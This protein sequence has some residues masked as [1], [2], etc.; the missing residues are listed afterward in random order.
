M[1][2]GYGETGAQ[3]HSFTNKGHSAGTLEEG[4]PTSMLSVPLR[5][6]QG[7]GTGRDQNEGF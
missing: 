1:G 2:K 5:G 7:K 4:V 6:K 3:G